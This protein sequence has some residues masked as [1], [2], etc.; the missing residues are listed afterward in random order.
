MKTREMLA[1]V[2]LAGAAGTVC[3]QVSA[4]YLVSVDDPVLAPGETTIVRV[5]VLLEPGGPTGVYVYQ[6]IAY[7]Q[8]GPGGGS[9][10]ELVAGG[11]ILAGFI[12]GTFCIGDCNAD[13]V[14]TISDFACFQTQ[15]VAGNPYAD[16][17]L[18]GQRTI[19][20]FGCFQTAF[21]AGCTDCP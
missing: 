21:V 4:T 3:A 20:D 9:T 12:P 11:Q 8:L 14:Q 2:V 10:T 15:F 16:C 13:G 7:G 1:V 19:A 18:D 6:S 17:N 5:S